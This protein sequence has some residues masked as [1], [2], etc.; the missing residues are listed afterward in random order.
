MPVLTTKKIS[1]EKLLEIISVGKAKKIITEELKDLTRRIESINSDEQILLDNAELK[2]LIK[3]QGVRVKQI[4]EKPYYKK[5]ALNFLLVLA[6]TVCMASMLVFIFA[7]AS[8]VSAVAFSTVIFPLTK[9]GIIYATLG[10]SSAGLFI[11]LATYFKID[12]LLSPSPSEQTEIDTLKILK[13][14]AEATESKDKDIKQ[15]RQNSSKN[16]FQQS[17][18]FFSPA[19]NPSNNTGAIIDFDKN[20]QYTI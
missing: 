17:Q 1:T 15:D 4:T 14:S 7:V 8:L 20:T 9:I 12:K 5:V 6:F 16:T 2:Q 3:I 18:P 11:A 10:G 19:A 13:D